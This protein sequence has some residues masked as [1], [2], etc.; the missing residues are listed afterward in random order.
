MSPAAGLLLVGQVMPIIQATV[1]RVV[2]PVGAEDAG[3]LVQDTL[4]MAA[5]LV[6]S[7]EARGK[8][9]YPGSVAYYAIQHAKHGRRSY[10]AIRTD[11]MCPAAQLDENVRMAAMDEA[12]TGEQGDEMTLHDLLPGRW[13]DPSQAAAR[14]LDWAELL[15][16][17][18][19]RDVALLQTTINGESLSLLAD[20]FG[21]SPARVT[22]LKRELGRQISLRWGP[23]ALADV[24]RSPAWVGSVNAAR[25]RQACR[26]ER[27]R[28]AWS[29]RR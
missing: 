13:E 24:A 11:A 9:I 12:I 1:P 18:N 23:S 22:Q 29:C 17:C 8:P 16:D 3:E 25:E 21:V 26:H 14:E 10:G 4:T 15:E 28:G 5:Q 2:K 7:L 27:A 19:E 6:E 20:Q